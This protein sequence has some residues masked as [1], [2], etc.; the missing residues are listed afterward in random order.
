MAKVR[1]V[2]NQG[3]MEMDKQPEGNAESG[4]ENT[5]QETTQTGEEVTEGKAPEVTTEPA[6][7]EAPAPATG[8]GEKPEGEGP[9]GETK[10]QKFARLIGPRVDKATIALRAVG[11][12][13]GPNYTSSPEWRKKVMDHLNAEFNALDAV[14]AGKEKAKGGG[15]SV[16]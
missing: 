3:V 2:G 1:N 9:K 11:Q 6:T 8:D 14:A 10:A 16:D 5:T 12:L 15:F 7:G 4:A 13:F